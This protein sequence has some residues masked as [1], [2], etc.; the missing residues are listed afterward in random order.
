MALLVFMNK[1]L[2]EQGPGHFEYSLAA[3]A[4]HQQAIS[5]GSNGKYHQ[6]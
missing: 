1:V 2:L 6:V 3:L 5:H 4:L